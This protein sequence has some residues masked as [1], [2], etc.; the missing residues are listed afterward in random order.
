MP[1]DKFKLTGFN[2]NLSR[3]T[4][5]LDLDLDQTVVEQAGEKLLDMVRDGHFCKIKARR[6]TPRERFALVYEP[7]ARPGGERLSSR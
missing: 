6:R 7:E 5:K 4:E 3:A 2:H 1:C